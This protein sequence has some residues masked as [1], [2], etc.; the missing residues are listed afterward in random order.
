MNSTPK[1]IT[2]L[3]IYTNDIQ[4]ITGKSERQSRNILNNIKAF[5]KKEKHQV[6]SI[7]EFCDYMGIDTTTVQNLIK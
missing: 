4:L 5:Y 3:C 2:R 6:I 1:K 7:Q